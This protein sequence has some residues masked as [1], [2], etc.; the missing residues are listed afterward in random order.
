ML[1]A[2]F[3]GN[4]LTSIPNGLLIDKYDWA[5]NSIGSAFVVAI[6]VTAIAPMAAASLLAT[7]ALR[8]I[9]GM[10][11]SGFGP[12]NNRLIAHWSPPDE[13]GKFVAALFGTDIG[14]VI[15]WSICGV[16]IEHFGWKWAFYVPAIAC[17]LF[18][19][20]WMYIVHDSPTQHP[21]ITPQERDY[22]ADSQRGVTAVASDDGKHTTWPPIGDILTCAPFWSLL[23]L[24]FGHMWGMFFL[25]NAAP[26][27]LNTVL[28]FDL[29]STGFLSSSPYLLRLVTGL[30]F[31][32]LGDVIKSRGWL[33][34]ATVRK[35]GTIFCEFVPCNQCNISF[36][37]TQ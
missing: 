36:N 16:L 4:T 6:I 3:W 7:I 8:F 11:T 27:F 10:V 33:K 15:T 26:M 22:I 25:L 32:A 9:L 17:T 2:Y 28:G 13:K 34:T 20:L 14:T 21:R 30:M 24:Q 12:A 35:A 29:A 23:L 31:G 18:T 1:G 5:K 37:R 19:M